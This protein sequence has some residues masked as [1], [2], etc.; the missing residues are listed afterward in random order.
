MRSAVISR[1]AD[2]HLRWI[3]VNPDFGQ[4]EVDPAVVNLRHSKRRSREGPLLR[5]RERLFGF[6]D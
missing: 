2:V 6:G 3:T 5:R 4:V 1:R